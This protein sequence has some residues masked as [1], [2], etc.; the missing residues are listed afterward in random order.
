MESQ[1]AK[2]RGINK[3]KQP[4]KCHLAGKVREGERKTQQ[5]Q[6]KDDWEMGTWEWESARWLTKSGGGRA[7][8]SGKQRIK[9]R[10]GGTLARIWVMDFIAMATSRYRVLA[11]RNFGPCIPIIFLG[12]SWLSW[13]AVSVVAL[14]ARRPFQQMTNW[15]TKRLWVMRVMSA[16]LKE[17][18]HQKQKRTASETSR[19]RE[20][21]WEQLRNRLLV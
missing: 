11:K 5:C 19:E 3:R 20:E 15:L 18:R 16:T 9:E 6:R 21:A 2:W 17:I 13:P 14:S 8:R 4:V 1:D 12:L 10:Q 7:W